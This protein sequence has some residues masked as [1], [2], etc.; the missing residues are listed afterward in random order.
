MNRLLLPKGFKDPIWLEGQ[1]KNRSETDWRRLGK[2]RALALFHNMAERVPAYKDFLK[3][4]KINHHRIVSIKDFA[5]LP[6]VDKDNY[7]L[8]YPRG[9][10]CWDGDFKK[11]S[12]TISTT[13]GS[14]GKP[15]YFPR[16]NSQD[17][18]YA[19]TAELYLRAN[20]DIQSR[21]TLYI[22]AFPM[23]AWIGGLFTY[24]A[25]KIIAERGKY[26]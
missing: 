1:L 7:L 3:K 2:R 25:L 10:L 14:T 19:V 15:F 4:H 12:W 6:T 9:A 17:W 5:N 23:G 16:Q 18:Q 13:S 8:A 11:T 21:S 24:E 22:V 20:F 26:N